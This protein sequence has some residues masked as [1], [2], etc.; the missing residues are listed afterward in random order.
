MSRKT[1][2]TIVQTCSS[3]YEKMIILVEVIDLD[4]DDNPWVPGA[5]FISAV[6]TLNTQLT[7]AGWH[8]VDGQEWLCGKHP[9]PE[10]KK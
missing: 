8:L 3:C 7:N 4:K 10:V 9:A 2:T 6:S 1:E 5:K